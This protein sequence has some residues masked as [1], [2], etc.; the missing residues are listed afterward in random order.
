MM[1]FSW[2]PVFVT[3]VSV[4]RQRLFT[5]L[6]IVASGSCGIEPLLDFVQDMALK[7]R[8]DERRGKQTGKGD[9][10]NDKRRF[11]GEK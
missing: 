9:G 6:A 10:A 8:V 3:S 4:S 7:L 5:L 1:H 2:W 11:G